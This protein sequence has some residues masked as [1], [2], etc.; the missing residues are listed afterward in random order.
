M[1]DK[2]YLDHRQEK[3]VKNNN[4]I[5]SGIVVFHFCSL[6]LTNICNFDGPQA[7]ISKFLIW[8]FK[9]INW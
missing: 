6:V 2:F 8:H 4:I 1:A 5:R 3:K 9:N 7:I